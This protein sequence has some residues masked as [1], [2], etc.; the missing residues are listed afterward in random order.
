MCKLYGGVG[1]GKTI[2]IPLCVD[3]Q[4]FSFVENPLAAREKIGLPLDRPILLTVR[5]LVARMGLE[6]LIA[7]MSYVV[8]EVPD[9][10]LLVG[11]KEYLENALRK[12]VKELQIE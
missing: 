10:L 12:Q 6:N 7:A 3:T 8:K 4:R 5:R 11:G 1:E 2:R 9:A